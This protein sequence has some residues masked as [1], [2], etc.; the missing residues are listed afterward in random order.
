[1]ALYGFNDYTTGDTPGATDFDGLMRQTF[2]GFD[3]TTERDSELSAVLEEGLLAQT[4]E[5]E[6][7][8]RYDGDDWEILFERVKGW[9]PEVTQGSTVANT[10]EWATYKRSFGRWDASFHTTFTATG[11]AGEPITISPPFATI[12]VGGTFT[13]YD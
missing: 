9:S 13:F 10:L 8:W 4:L 2:M 3:D 12:G 5:D 6:T 11:S 1:M 7:F